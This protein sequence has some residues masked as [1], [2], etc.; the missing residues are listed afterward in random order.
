MKDHL[1]I[2]Y[3]AKVNNNQYRKFLEEW[4]DILTHFQVI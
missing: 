1:E 4:G 2:I 3:L